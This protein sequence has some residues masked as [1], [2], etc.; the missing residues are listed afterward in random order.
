MSKRTSFE[1]F[2]DFEKKTPE[3]CEDLLVQE[4]CIPQRL[5]RAMVQELMLL[6]AGRCYRMSS[7]LVSLCLWY[8]QPVLVLSHPK[9]EPA[10]DKDYYSQSQRLEHPA[11]HS[12]MPQLPGR[13]QNS[14]GK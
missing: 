8:K 12:V 7:C 1:L 2:I 13:N 5:L 10:E 6:G 3:L 14:I 4:P 9:N 11:I